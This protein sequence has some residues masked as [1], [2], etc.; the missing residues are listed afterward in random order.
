M[1]L[2]TI[3]LSNVIT[4]YYKIFFLLI[5]KITWLQCIVLFLICHFYFPLGLTRKEN[6]KVK[7]KWKQ[8]VVMEVCL[9][10]LAEASRKK[11]DWNIDYLY[12][13]IIIFY[14]PPPR[15]IYI[16]E[17]NFIFAIIHN[18]CSTSIKT[19]YLGKTWPCKGSFLFLL[20][21]GIEIYINTAK[22]SFERGIPYLK[23]SM[24]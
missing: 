15:K 14:L 16:Y 8:H 21:I 12:Y 7:I 5:S 11:A 18:I 9:P 24:I 13:F 20:E 17:H 22:I 1:T 19:K 2:I 4:D 10:S 6:R 3:S 23:D